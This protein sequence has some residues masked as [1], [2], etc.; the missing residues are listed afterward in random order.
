M[1]AQLSAP[2]TNPYPSLPFVLPVLAVEGEEGQGEAGIRGG[3]CKGSSPRMEVAGMVPRKQRV[4][5]EG[6]AR[7]QLPTYLAALMD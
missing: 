3:R 4:V 2:S 1:P 7:K 5:E 6:V